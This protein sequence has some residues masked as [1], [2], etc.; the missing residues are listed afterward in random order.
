[1]FS[2]FL[3]FVF[4]SSAPGFTVKQP[5][6]AFFILCH[7]EKTLFNLFISDEEI[8]IKMLC[9]F[10]LCEARL[11]GKTLPFRKK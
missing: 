5:L 11:S 7:F 3:L 9:D 10:Y 8:L 1:V 2:C 6:A 4:Y